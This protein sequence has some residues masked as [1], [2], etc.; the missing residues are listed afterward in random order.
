MYLAQNS[1]T[2]ACGCFASELFL[3]PRHVFTQAHALGWFDVAIVA[4]C[5]FTVV[6]VNDSVDV[7]GEKDRLGAESRLKAAWPREPDART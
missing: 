3:D 1:S 4:S 2:T 5:V 6:L 7:R